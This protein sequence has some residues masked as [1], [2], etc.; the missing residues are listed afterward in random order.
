MTTVTHIEKA[1]FV[2]L[3]EIEVQR[4]ILKRADSVICSSRKSLRLRSG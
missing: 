1:A 4:A 2:T 3:S